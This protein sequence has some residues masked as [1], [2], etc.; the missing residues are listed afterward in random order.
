M[1][2]F[3]RLFTVAAV[4]CLWVG[5]E[6]D[7]GSFSG[8]SLMGGDGAREPGSDAASEYSPP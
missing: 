7:E 6:G 5:D 2:S 4:A 3:K 8:G 1:T